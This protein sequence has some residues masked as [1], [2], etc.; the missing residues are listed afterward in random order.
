M[1][2]NERKNQEKFK[3]LERQYTV[4][5]R[6]LNKS[7]EEIAELNA[8]FA[9]LEARLIEMDCDRIIA[10]IQEAQAN[11]EAKKKTRKRAKKDETES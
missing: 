3:Q 1:T 8:K 4:L 7:E 5:V 2:I 9:E 11:A 10:Q 6:C